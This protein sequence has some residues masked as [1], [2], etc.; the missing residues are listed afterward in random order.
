LVDQRGKTKGIIC[1]LNIPSKIGALDCLSYNSGELIDGK[2]AVK[3]VLFDNPS[4]GGGELWRGSS[5]TVPPKKVP[6]LV[7]IFE[8][9]VAKSGEQFKT[10][11]PGA[12]IG[13][14]I[15][16]P[17]LGPGRGHYYV[18]SR[19]GGPKWGVV[20]GKKV[21][22][23]SLRTVTPSAGLCLGLAPSHKTGTQN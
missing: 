18:H 13:G 23:G 17:L 8:G 19:T 9:H 3:E 1:P 15:Q 20:D 21:Q 14:N 4:R 11:W 16:R 10:L 12:A 7:C 22:R 2:R 6:G 5:A